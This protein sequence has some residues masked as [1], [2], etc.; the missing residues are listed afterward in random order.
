MK[1][2]ITALF[3]IIAT[4]SVA[5][6]QFQKYSIRES[7]VMKE[8]RQEAK[9]VFI[10][11]NAKIYELRSLIEL[12]KQ[13]LIK[14]EDVVKHYN[15]TV[16]GVMKFQKTFTGVVKRIKESGDA[17]AMFLYEKEQAR[18]LFLKA[19]KVNAQSIQ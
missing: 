13:G 9:P 5:F 10:N 2:I 14:K 15:Y 19:A 1:K 7:E 3:A 17:Y 11:A 18:I 6:G 8:I 12:A 16:G 4:I